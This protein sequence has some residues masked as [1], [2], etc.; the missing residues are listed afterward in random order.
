MKKIFLLLVFLQLATFVL[1]QAKTENLIIVSFDGLRWQ[2]LFGGVDDSLLHDKNFTSDSIELMKQFWID[3]PEARRKKLLPFL[4]N[5]VAVKGQL[6]GNRW[7]GSKASVKNPY[8]FSYPGYNEIFTGYPDTLVNSNDKK[9][10]KNVTVLEY[11]NAQPALKGKVA[12]FTSWDVFDAIFNE[13]RCGFLVSAGFDE[14]PLK[15]PAVNLLNEMQKQAFQPFGEQVRPDLL[16]YYLAKEYLKQKKP[17]LLYIGFDDTDDWAHN[18]KY[19]YYLQAA[20]LT[21]RY[22]ADLW[23]TIQSMPEYKDKTTMIITTDH[24]R[25]DAV[26]KEWT[27][28]GKKIKG[29]DEIWMGFLGIGVEARG[30]IKNGQVY[31]AQL[32]QTIARLLGYTYQANHPIEKAIESIVR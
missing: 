20:N 26:K 24:G 8:R 23:T 16:T 3:K 5:T 31:Q 7:L 14:V 12:A 1:S 28:H 2:E 4:W 32:A 29:A 13:T 15:S 22:I 27:S 9:P 17:K 6:Y 19:D 25:G 21:D 10:N 11:L 18:G 30:E